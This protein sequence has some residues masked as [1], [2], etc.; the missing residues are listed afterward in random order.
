[1]RAAVAGRMMLKRVMGKASFATLQDMSGRIQL[2]ITR[3]ALGEA[4]V[5]GLQALGS[6]RHPRRRGHAVP[7]QDRRAVHQGRA[8]AAA[9]QVAA[10][11]AGE[12][13]RPGRPG[14]EVPPA[15]PRPDH[16]RGHA[17]GVRGA[18][19][20]DP[21]DPRVL[22]RARLSRGRNADDAA[23]ARRRGGAALRHA[24]QR[25]GHAAVPAHRAGAVSQAPGGGRLREGVRDQPQLPQRRH[26]DPAQSRVHHAGVL[27]GLSGLPLPDG[28][29]RAA[30]ARSGA[31]GASAAPR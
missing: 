26:L 4:D 29:H 9:R 12:V 23:A 24:S 5:R 6:G 19:A 27:R 10:P 16:Q 28:P 13:P 21:G 7:H 31:E 8:A 20:G 17:P 11:A 18:L 25:A 30:A 22:R 15:L 14:A 2:Y 3:D 1:M